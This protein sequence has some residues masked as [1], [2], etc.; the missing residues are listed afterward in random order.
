MKFYLLWTNHDA[1]NMYDLR[2]S[3]FY[4]NVIWKGAVDRQEF[5]RV[6]LRFIDKYLTRPNYYTIDGKPVLMIYEPPNLIRGLGGM[7]HVR[8]A[9]DWF[10][11]SAVKAGLKG[12]HLQ[13]TMWSETMR[14]VSGIDGE[15]DVPAYE[16][17]DKLGFDSI[18]HY[19]FVHFADIKQPYPDLLKAVQK[20]WESIDSKSPVPYF[21]HIS[22][23]W[24]NNPRYKK[25]ND[26]IMQENTPENVEIGLRMAKKYADDH[27]NQAPLITINA[28]NEWPESSY[29]MP[30]SLNGYGYLEAVRNVFGPAR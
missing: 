5:E 11:E 28:W 14:N 19:Q 2:N 30:D 22:L 4:N 17:I 27:P 24:D 15:R 18:T 26:Y 25:Y 13:M 20:E 9:L 12:L 10:R 16:V 23:G 29:L 21:P 3:E 7:E 1:T 8:R 6:A